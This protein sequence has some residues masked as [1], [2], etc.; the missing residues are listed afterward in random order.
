MTKR[1][2]G[3]HEV[4]GNRKKPRGPRRPITSLSMSKPIPPNA[5]TGSNNLTSLLPDNPPSLP[6]NLFTGT[7]PTAT[8]KPYAAT[9][10]KQGDHSKLT[11]LLQTYPPGGYPTAA[12]GMPILNGTGQYGN[13]H[14]GQS[15]STDAIATKTSLSSTTPMMGIGAGLT[16]RVSGKGSRG[17]GAGGTASRKFVDIFR[18][19]RKGNVYLKCCRP[20][21]K[22]PLAAGN[23]PTAKVP[24]TIPTVDMETDD[25]KPMTYEEKRQL[26]LDINNLPSEKLAP[27]VD[28]RRKANERYCD[29]FLC[30]VFFQ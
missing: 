15:H 10:S 7:Q 25:S 23:P 17:G 29:K 16:G 2:K 28:V 12:S 9:A 22:A 27:V 18:I 3:K 13:T 21:K 6:P 11:G 8:R 1:R 20:A 26:S 30:F 5:L 24:P 14:P 4:K 19:E